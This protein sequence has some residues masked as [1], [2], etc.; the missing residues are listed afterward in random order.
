MS[1]IQFF[2]GTV[3][4]KS[5]PFVSVWRTDNVSSGS[6]A[7]NQI[8]LPLDPSGSY[9]F[10]VDWG[11]GS[12]SYVSSHTDPG[13]THTYSVAGTYTVSMKGKVNG[14]TFQAS[15]DRLKILEIRNWGPLKI[16]SNYAPNTGVFTNCVNLSIPADDVPD[17]LGIGGVAGMFYGCTGLSIK[18][19]NDWIMHSIT[20]TSSMFRSSGFNNAITNWVFL[21]PLNANSMFRGGAYNHPIAWTV[22]GSVNALEMFWSG[23]FN[24]PIS[25]IGGA[26]TNS[27]SMFRATPFNHPITGLNFTGN[28]TTALMF[29]NNPSFNQNVAGMAMGAVTTASNMFLGGGLSTVNYDALLTGW[30]SQNLRNNVTFHAGTSKYSSDGAASRSSIIST[31]NWTITDQ[32]LAA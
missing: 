25:I 4:Q 27:A 13:V 30:A 28:M 24:S 20:N 17:L 21:G 14:W 5:N 22:G 16:S 18:K 6:S 7:N 23:S 32:G 15:G 29:N 3:K 19:P 9:S 12:T 31:R 26:I 2:K 11:D 1:A 8:K 10:T